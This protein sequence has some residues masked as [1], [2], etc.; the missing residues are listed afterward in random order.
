MNNLV[1]TRVFEAD[2]FRVEEDF[3]GTVT[4]LADLYNKKE[5]RLV[6]GYL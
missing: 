2:E 6:K 5:I 4:F 1:D 3:R